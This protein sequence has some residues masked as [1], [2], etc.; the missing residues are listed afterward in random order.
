[1]LDIWPAQ[2]WSLRRHDQEP[3]S[4]A[5]RKRLSHHD[6]RGQRCLDSSACASESELLE[7]VTAYTLPFKMITEQ[8]F[9]LEGKELGPERFRLF[10]PNQSSELNFIDFSR[11]K[12]PEFR[13][14]RDLYETLLTAMD[15][16][17]P[18]LMTIFELF[19][20]IPVCNHRTDLFWIN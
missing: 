5:S 12:R 10:Y 14:K 1:M 19:S 9:P 7:V 6:W 4:T 11:E 8:N 13:R 18:F 20:V 15:Q 3:E 2:V 17:L 16:C